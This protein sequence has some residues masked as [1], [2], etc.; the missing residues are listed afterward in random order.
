VTNHSARRSQGLLWA[1]AAVLACIVT[2]FGVLVFR[3]GG[4]IRTA[5]RKSGPPSVLSTDPVRGDASAAL[6]II[7]YGDYQCP[8]CRSEQ[9]TLKVLL[10]KYQTNVRLVWKDLPLQE[11]H[12]EALTAAEAAR[13]AQEQGKFWEMHDALFAHQEEISPSLIATLADQLGLHRASFDECRQSDRMIS[14]IQES[15]Q[16]GLDAGVDG[17]PYYFIN[18][19]PYTQL[20][21]TDTIERII[22]ERQ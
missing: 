22:N 20:P 1:F 2:W 12:A 21:T 18:N 17:T 3:E 13:C 8:F 11:V 10:A 4:K 15:A 14:R 9:N 6:T 5:E 16:G 7:E 19:E